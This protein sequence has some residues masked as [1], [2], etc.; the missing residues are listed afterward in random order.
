LIRWDYE[1]HRKGLSKPNSKQMGKDLDQRLLER[2]ANQFRPEELRPPTH[3]GVLRD[4]AGAVN[5]DPDDLERVWRAASGSAH[6]RVWPSLALQHVVP[7]TEYE[8]G[9]FR[10]IRVPD[11]RA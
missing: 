4:V 2:A 8:P 11:P 3:F 7:L 9:Q 1:E 10:T 6:G 5:L